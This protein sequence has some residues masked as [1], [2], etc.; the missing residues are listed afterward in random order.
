MGK[1]LSKN[2]IVREVRG[3]SRL[4]VQ[5]DAELD[6]E[7]LVRLLRRIFLGD[8]ADDVIRAAASA[9]YRD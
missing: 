5:V 2:D 4:R 3:N 6:L 7:D 8:A 1:E 9:L